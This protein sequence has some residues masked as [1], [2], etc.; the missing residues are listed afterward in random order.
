MAEFSLVD[1]LGSKVVLEMNAL[2][3]DLEVALAMYMPWLN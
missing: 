3:D 2:E 1:R